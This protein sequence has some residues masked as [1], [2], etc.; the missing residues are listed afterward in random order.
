MG[1]YMLYI[2]LIL[3]VIAIVIVA[4]A[5]VVYR[6]GMTQELETI[7]KPGVSLSKGFNGED[8]MPIGLAPAIDESLI[9]KPGPRELTKQRLPSAQEAGFED[10]KVEAFY[11]Q[12]AAFKCSENAEK[13]RLEL[14]SRGYRARIGSPKANEDGFHRV[15][16]GAFLNEQ[17]AISFAEKLYEQEGLAYMVVYGIIIMQRTAA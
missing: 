14:L 3:E 11:I 2:V 4:A 12:V 15:L 8:S 17:E 7:E 1:E 9:E 16:V 6:G 10:E 5:G 13:C